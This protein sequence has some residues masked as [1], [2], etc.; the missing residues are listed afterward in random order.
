MKRTLAVVID[1]NRV[2]CGKC[3]NLTDYGE[4]YSNAHCSVFLASM[5][6]FTDKPAGFRRCAPCLAAEK[7]T[8]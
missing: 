3:K 6:W 5:E 1:A 4:L 8:Q 7:A 2:T